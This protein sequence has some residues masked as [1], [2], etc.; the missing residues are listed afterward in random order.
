MAMNMF[1]N[2]LLLALVLQKQQAWLASKDTIPFPKVCSQ[3]KHHLSKNTSLSHIRQVYITQMEDN[4]TNLLLAPFTCITSAESDGNPSWHICIAGLGKQDNGED[5]EYTYLTIVLCG[6]Y[7]QTPIT[8]SLW[9]YPRE[10]D[11]LIGRDQ[12]KQDT[13]FPALQT[14]RRDRKIRPERK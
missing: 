1:S 12:T 4:I 2:G 6:S 13:K 3:I 8:P 9:Q 11:R 7:L 5:V 14:D 10:D